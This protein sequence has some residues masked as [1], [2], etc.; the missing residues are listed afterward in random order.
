MPPELRER[1]VREVRDVL[2]APAEAQRIAELGF[3]LRATGPQDLPRSSIGKLSGSRSGAP[4]RTEGA[5]PQYDV[6]TEPRE[7]RTTDIP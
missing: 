6:R 7:N 3:V 1:V 5:R 4:A 2:N